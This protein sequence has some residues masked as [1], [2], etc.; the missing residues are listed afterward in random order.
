MIYFILG[1]A[2]LKILLLYFIKNIKKYFLITS[3]IDIISGYLIIII[4]YIFKLYLKR[5]I[6]YI[7]ISVLINYIIKSNNNHALILI[8]IGSIELIT[9]IIL[10]FINKKKN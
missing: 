1:I 5:K 7:N 2:L 9:Y 10:I 8:L 6:T 3:I 4:D